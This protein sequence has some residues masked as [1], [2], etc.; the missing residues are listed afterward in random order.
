VRT[1]S[2]RARVTLVTLGLL[3]AVLAVVITS[4]TL[5]YEAHLRSDLRNRLTAAGEAVARAG[6]ASAA[7]GL[8][9]G[10]ALEGIATTVQKG[11]GPL[12]PGKDA[13][14]A[15]TK[16]GASIESIGSMLMLTQVLPDG[17]RVSF[18]ASGA[19]AS[20]SIRDLLALEFGVGLAALVVAGLLIRWGTTSALRP[21]TQVAETASAIAAG[22]RTRR[23]HPQR[24][25]TELG[26]MATAFDHMVD[27]LDQALAA[28]ARSEE[29]MRQF[30]AEAAHELRN[31]IAAL[32]ASAERLLRDQPD[33]PERD[34]LEASLAGDAARLGRLAGDLLDLAR[35]E[36]EGTPPTETVDLGSL[37]VAAVVDSRRDAGPD[38]QVQAESVLVQADASGITRVVRNLIENAIA[39]VPPTGHVDVTVRRDHKAVEVNVTDD[40]P[41]IAA[42]DRGRIFNRFTRLQ[43]G[44]T[45]GTGLGLAIARQIA[46]QHGGDLTCD[47]QDTGAS[48]TLRFPQGPRL[49]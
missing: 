30:V 15:P 46:R 4:V 3:V 26:V 14:P 22:D 11:A 45:P 16:T 20:R 31:P 36:A 19:Q 13:R 25:D 1:A 6:S 40:G 27:S 28:S 38:I 8:T 7:T 37:V 5:G 32:Q 35:L 41:G 49:R 39:A 10:L 24:T 42:A 17:T 44:S 48:F 47:E 18:S 33:R 34:E 2:L 43:P 9:R 23:L 12:P 21:M 29:A